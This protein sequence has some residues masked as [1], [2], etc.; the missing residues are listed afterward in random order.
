MTSRE[1]VLAELSE[2]PGTT[3]S[4]PDSWAD[5]PGHSLSPLH[6]RTTSPASYA[7]V[8]Q[9]LREHGFTI[10]DA[11]P[12]SSSHV[13]LDHSLVYSVSVSHTVELLA[14]VFPVLDQR[15]VVSEP[16]QSAARMVLR[17]WEQLL[18]SP[19]VHD[20]VLEEV[21]H[22]WDS[23]PTHVR[24]A[25]LSHLS[26]VTR[27]LVEAATSME[28]PRL[29]LKAHKAL[30]RSVRSARLRSLARRGVLRTHALHTVSLISGTSVVFLAGTDEDAATETAMLLTTHQMTARPVRLS[31]NPFLAALRYLTVA[32]PLRFTGVSV[33]CYDPPTRRFLTPRPLVAA[34]PARPLVGESDTALARS[35]RLAASEELWL[36]THQ[37]SRQVRDATPHTIVC[38]VLQG[39]YS[40][41]PESW[42][43]PLTK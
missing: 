2:V 32:L 38:S 29:L 7:V 16:H 31:R 22:A 25:M 24:E 9:V 33:V 42:Y 28:N 1:T 11:A 10:T 36:K 8:L 26:R 19:V 14:G 15:L 12:F 30:R 4:E 41:F 37:G 5:L 43:S 18:R 35:S 13:L 23:L 20:D 27:T 17:F 34:S 21:I 3:L 39:T 6:V 40:R